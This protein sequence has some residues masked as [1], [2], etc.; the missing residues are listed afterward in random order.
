MRLM[1]HAR[2]SWQVLNIKKFID[3][4][5][6]V[7]K[8]IAN[9]KIVHGGFC[10][11]CV[12]YMCAWDRDRQLTVCGIGEQHEKITITDDVAVFR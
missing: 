6:E 9:K 10:W 3:R 7:L 5:H 1:K 12:G 4:L 11:L 8:S 2:K